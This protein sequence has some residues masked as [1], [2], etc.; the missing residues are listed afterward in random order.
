MR[1]VCATMTI[2][3]IIDANANR[4]REALRVLEDAARFVLNDKSLTAACKTLR[5][6]VTACVQQFLHIARDRD[7]AGDVGTGLTTA[8]ESARAA[9]SDVVIAAGKRLGEALRSLEEYAKTIDAD[10]AAQLKQMR[11]RGYELEQ[12]FAQ[13][14]GNSIA[15]Q[16]RLCLLLTAALCPNNDWQRVAHA[17]LDGGC[18]C[19]QLREKQL[20]DRELLQHARV[21]RDMTNNRAALIINDRPDIAALVQADGVH[22]GQGDLSITQVRRLFGNTLRIGVSTHD[23]NELD[24]A[25]RDGADYVGIGAMFASTVK[26]DRIPAGAAFL[27]AA[28]ERHPDLPHLAIGGITPDNVGE[29]IAR[30]CR[31]V[32]VSTALCGAHDPLVATRRILEQLVSASV[33]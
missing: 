12:N 28:L 24:H 23:I 18:D 13:A 8:G 30:G 3:R 33:C 21:L 32:A 9:L 16:W 1:L 31:G 7:T 27:E 2:A 15:P 5:H 11:Y 29:L 25:A 20:S 19:I 22:L 6:D 10:A 4:A 26:S 14:F 17:A